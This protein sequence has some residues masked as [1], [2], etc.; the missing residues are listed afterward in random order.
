ME[1]T[2]LTDKTVNQLL[3]AFCSSDPTPG[4]GSAAALSGALGV[5]LLAMV[6]GLPKTKTGTLEARAALDE[7]RARLLDIRARLVD[8]VDR[9]TAAYDLVVAAFKKPKATDEEKAA[10]KTAVQEAMR[11]A[12][13][14]PIETMRACAEAMH[15]AATVAEHGNPSAKSDIAVG[16]QLITA[17]STGA[18]L[19]VEIN[20]GSLTDPTVV[21]NLTQQLRAITSEGANDVRRAYQEGGIVEL[22]QQAAARAGALHGRPQ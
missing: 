7:A 10:R 22:M 11:V 14:T 17:G 16:I 20:I 1:N 18:L 5:S 4:G 15:L 9:D 12:T 19:N 13:E 21:E 3:D 2:V 6:T 8:L